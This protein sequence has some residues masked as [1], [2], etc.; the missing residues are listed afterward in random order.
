LFL[1][2]FYKL[3]RITYELISYSLYESNIIIFVVIEIV[4][5]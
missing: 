2:Y 3:S 1:V 5:I 4:Y